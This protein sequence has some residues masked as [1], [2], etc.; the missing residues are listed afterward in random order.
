MPEITLSYVITTFN[1]MTFLKV[2]LKEL[3]QNRK[4]EEEIIVIDGGS[5]DGT[6]EYL[7]ELREGGDIDFYL[8]E[9]DKGE[10]H[11]FNKGFLLAKGTLI[12]VITD[13]DAFYHPVI[14]KCKEHMLLNPGI[15]IMA[16]N[17]GNINIEDINSL[18]W[19][20]SFQDD[21]NLWKE[22]HLK[23]FFFNGTCL[24]IRKSSL[25]LTGLFSTRALLADMEFTLRVTGVA[26]IAWCTGIISTRILNS[27][28]NNLK[29]AEKARIE[30]EKLCLFYDYKHAHIRKQEELR[31]RSAYLKIRS[32]L[33]KALLPGRRNIKT[34]LP[35][36]DKKTFTFEE[37]HDHCITWMAE[38][39]L[40]KEVRFLTR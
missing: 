10:S 30:D 38:N 26:D 39:E 17:M 19:S 37:I 35:E 33:V 3:I 34:V 1:K 24:M 2:V 11:G 28:S 15:D 40:N 32:Y 18:Y 31:N 8:S 27:Q 36:G 29:F 12:K 21:F 20:Y 14:Q 22:G 6:P 7:R 16:G 13:D 5:T 9:K 23:N 25:N 4:A